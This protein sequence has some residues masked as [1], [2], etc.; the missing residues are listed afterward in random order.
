MAKHSAMVSSPM[1]EGGLCMKPAMFFRCF[2]FV[3]LTVLAAATRLPAQVQVSEGA[4]SVYVQT[5]A[6]GAVRDP[7]LQV[8]VSNPSG[9]PAAEITALTVTAAGNGTGNDLSDLAAGGVELYWDKNGNGRVTTTG[10]TPDQLLG[11]GSYNFDNGTV[12]LTGFTVP[13]ATNQSLNLLVV[14]TLGP[15]AGTGE[16]FRARIASNSDVQVRNA[17]T[18]ASMTVSGAPVEGYLRTVGHG[19]LT[20]VRL[21]QTPDGGVAIPNAALLP[22]VNL[23]LLADDV[24]DLSISALRFKDVNTANFLTGVLPGSVRLFLQTAKPTNPATAVASGSFTADNGTITL[25]PASPLLIARN[26]S[27]TIWVTADLV[28][29]VSETIGRKYQ[30]QVPTSNPVTAQ[31]VFS[32]ASPTVIGA[33]ANGPEWQFNYNP[34]FFTTPNDLGAILMASS[35]QNYPVLAFQVTNNPDVRSERV[36]I[37]HFTFH[38]SGSLN[39][40]TDVTQARLYRDESPYGRYSANDVLLATASFTADN[41][42]LVFSFASQNVTLSAGGSMRF[43]V[44]YNLNGNASNGETARLG[45]LTRD[46]MSIIG[47]VSLVNGALIPS[48]FYGYYKTV[49]QPRAEFTLETSEARIPSIVAPA[50]KNFPLMG[51]SIK[52]STDEDVL[53]QGLNLKFTGPLTETGYFTGLKVYYDADGDGVIDP[54][55]RQLGTTVTLT[56]ATGGDAQLDLLIPEAEQYLIARGQTVRFTLMGDVSPTVTGNGTETFSIVAETASSVVAAGAGSAAPVKYTTAMPPFSLARTIRNPV[57]QVTNYPSP[58]AVLGCINFSYGMI[59]CRFTPPSGEDL[60]IQRIRFSVDGTLNDAQY[61]STASVWNDTNGDLLPQSAEVTKPFGYKLQPKPVSSDNGAGLIDFPGDPGPLE[62]L[63]DARLTV[64]VGFSAPDPADAMAQLGKSVTAYQ[65]GNL[66]IEGVGARSG[67]P[68]EVTNAAG[69]NTGR[70]LS[71]SKGTLT[72]TQQTIERTEAPPK[73]SNVEVLALLL[74]TAVIEPVRIDRLKLTPSGTINEAIHIRPNG[75]KIYMDDNHNGKVDSAD[76]LYATANPPSADNG[77]ITFTAANYVYSNMVDTNPGSGVHPYDQFLVTVDL[78]VNTP[79]DTTV[80]FALVSALDLEATGVGSLVSYTVNSE[81]IYPTPPAFIGPSVLVR[82]GAMDLRVN[83]SFAADVDN[84]P[85]VSMTPT[86][87]NYEVLRLDAKATA[88]EDVRL[89]GITIQSTGA[90]NEK[91]DLV[92]VGLY[93]GAIAV[94][95]LLTTGTFSADNAGILLKDFRTTVTLTTKAATELRLAFSGTGTGILGKDFNLSIQGIGL[96]SLGLSS[97]LPIQRI[98]PADPC[99]AV[100]IRFDSGRLYVRA[101]D[102]KQYLLPIPTGEPSIIQRLKFTTSRTEPIRIQDIAVRASGTADESQ[103]AQ[104]GALLMNNRAVTSNPPV[105]VASAPF[106]PGDNGLAN[107]RNMNILVP[108]KSNTGS[109]YSLDIALNPASAVSGTTLQMDLET[110]GTLLALGETSGANAHVIFED[111]AGGD[112]LPN[113]P[114]ITGQAVML[115]NGLVVLKKGSRNPANAAIGGDERGLPLMQ[116]R[117]EV[118]AE[119]EAVTIS[120]VRMVGL[121]SVNEASLVAPLYLY[122]D[123]NADGKANT[124]DV[125]IGEALFSGDNGE[126][127]FTGLNLT[128]AAGATATWLFAADLTGAALENR[129][130]QI[131]FAGV[132]GVSGVGQLTTE[133]INFSIGSPAPVGAVYILGPPRQTNARAWEIYE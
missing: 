43:L 2:V 29:A 24:E 92:S 61:I 115:S 120:D 30:I 90:A 131:G 57:I 96:Q 4:N 84:K 93:K 27:V 26:S 56:A 65:I 116:V 33:G 81:I 75:I 109:A 74:K 122:L 94:N 50:A 128:Y 17:S 89:T 25:S 18:K 19:A 28:D 85:A 112:S 125:L 88:S 91:S 98:L 49:G 121:G 14:Y 1:T 58:S 102:Y 97:G 31:G 100:P 42:A 62:R 80:Q 20:F 78:D 130:L 59:G 60:L 87:K 108:A 51:F 23:Q 95:N 133:P 6:A 104:S 127:Q 82:R 64:G 66:V 47:D 21:I 44:T 67:R 111:F 8:A 40:A 45:L 113:A 11:G 5:I 86:A 46:D 36:A 105:L 106:V 12:T 110:T 118:T 69:D 73:G 39:E 7:M 13:L 63:K 123:V 34:M 129:T 114:K 37:S 126:A 15:G 79:E 107:L 70:T 72:V 71:F 77:T 132:G 101:T 52:A 124:G 10:A 103:V 54:T 119:L 3:I 22:L 99:L 32:S 83:S 9:S 41:G 76:Y 53:F 55:D 68:I 117:V 16:S 48:P 35:A 38:A